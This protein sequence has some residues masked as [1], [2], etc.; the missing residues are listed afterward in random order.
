[1][2]NKRR[3][4]NGVR[5]QSIPARRTPGSSK[6]QVSRVVTRVGDAP[7]V[8]FEFFDDGGSPI[9]QAVHGY[10]LDD[11]FDPKD[12]PLQDARAEAEA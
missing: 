11:D 9:K 8:V 3:E 4:Q 1:M 7:V 6:K 5:G 12:L 2:Q 10:A